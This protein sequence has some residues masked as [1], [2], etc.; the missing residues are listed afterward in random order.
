MVGERAG[1]QGLIEASR[2]NFAE[3]RFFV[4]AD[5]QIRIVEPDSGSAWV[6][7][8]ETCVPLTVEVDELKD[9][10]ISR[11]GKPSNLVSREAYRVGGRS[12]FIATTPRIEDGRRVLKLIGPEGT[13]F[14]KVQ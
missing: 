12:I 7:K 4:S 3:G 14:E 5:D 10:E 13:T 1:E 2:N 9:G 6:V 11:T 8:V